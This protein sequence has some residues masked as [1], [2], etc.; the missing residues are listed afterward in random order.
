MKKKIDVGVAE[1]EPTTFSSDF[2]GEILNFNPFLSFL[3]TISTHIKFS[4]I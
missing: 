1:S 2:T 3:D 4:Y